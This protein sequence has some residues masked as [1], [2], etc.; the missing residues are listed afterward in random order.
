M[1]ELEYWKR[2]HALGKISR[3]HFLGR[4][5][6]LG[7]SASAIAT[8][9]AEA[10]AYAADTPTKGGILR[11]GAAGGSTTDSLNPA[12][13]TDTVTL[14]CGFAICNLLVENSPDNKPAPDLAESWEAKPGAAEWI[15]NLRKGV[16]FSNGKEFDAD[17]AIYSLNLHRGDSKSGASGPMK[18]I[19]DIKKLDKNQ[20]Q[21]TLT[22]A[23]A[24]LP[25]VLSD[26]HLV[27]VPNGYADWSGLVGTGAFTVDK[28]DPGVRV[29]L[30]KNSKFWR[31][32]RG[33]LDGCE[34]TVINDNSARM[35]ALIS[36]QVDVIHRVDPKTVATLKKSP[37][38]EIVQAPGG[39][40]AILPMF[41]DTAPYD[42]V[43]IRMALKYSIDRQQVLRTMF[44]G[45]GTVG[46]DHPIPKGDPFYHSQL[47]QTAYDLDKAKFHFKQAGLTDPKIL[48]SASDAAFNGAVDMAT[49]FQATAAKAGIK[50]DV[51]KEPADGFWDN[52]WL[53]APFSTSY[54]GGRP[55]ATQMLGVAYKSDAPWNDTHWKVPK[56]DKLL[57]DARAELDEAKRKEYIWAMQEMLHSDG[58]ALIPVF[59]DWID[60]HNVKVGG[61]TPHSGFD[62]DNGRICEK[63][64]LKA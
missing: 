10:D 32:D 37:N 7:A 57:S 8:L 27:M 41:C 46:N 19:S 9:V 33:H 64:W 49:L 18:A 24:D 28:F 38:I 21:I 1:S 22:S 58:G 14:L 23:D 48:I 62:F 35:N 43:D 12:T 2:Q 61:H 30:K 34:I 50:I 11:I 20:I 4:A 52:V 54:W 63:A 53:K 51:K 13:W 60:A 47:P 39:W 26:Y 40:H 31:P 15:I 5:A 56:F 59:R 17:D 42:N 55:A 6:A 25:Y 44:S 3:R 36:G 16:Q 45:F 29:S